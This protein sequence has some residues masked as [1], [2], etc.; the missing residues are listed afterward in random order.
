MTSTPTIPT[1][2]EIYERLLIFICRNYMVDDPLSI[3]R[4]TSLVDQGIIDSLGLMEIVT[5]VQRSFSITIAD[6]ELD[7]RNFGSVDAIVAFIHRRCV[8]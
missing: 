5:F 1:I 7:R 4:T 8:P 3:D 6:E 2:E